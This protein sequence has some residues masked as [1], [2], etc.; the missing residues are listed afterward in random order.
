MSPHPVTDV[1]ATLEWEAAAIPFPGESA[2]GDRAVVAL[3]DQCALVAAVDGLGHGPDAEA[4]GQ[5]AASVLERSVG[6][7]PTKAIHDCHQA[8]HDT[9]GAALSLASIDLR[10]RTVTWLGVGNVEARLLHAAEPLPVT[11]S[12]LLLGGVVGHELPRLSAQT[13][14]IDHG[15]LLI[16]ATDGIRSDFADGLVPSGSCQDIAERIL[17]ENALGSDD[18]LVLVIRYL[19]TT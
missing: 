14:T 6:H 11:E 17:H 16:F 9:R 10:K 4:A 15:D 19:T 2:L 7:G 13:T 3:A 5:A 18:A 8:L 12:L 1:G